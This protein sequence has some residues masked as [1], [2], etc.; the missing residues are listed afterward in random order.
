MADKGFDDIADSTD[1]L[2]TPL[3]GLAAVEAALR[4]QICKD[5]YA[6]PML[7]SCNHTFCS[8]CIRR[9]L[10][11]DGKCPACRS[12][13]E[14]SKLRSNWSMEEAVLAFVRTR[15]DVL[16][17]ARKPPTVLVETVEVPVATTTTTASSAS[18][19]P[20]H[21]LDVDEGKEY[22]AEDQ[23]A[24]RLRSSARRSKTRGAELTAEMAR[25]EASFSMPSSHSVPDQT[26]NDG[27]VACPI[28][29]ERMKEVQVDRH[30][31]SSCPGTPQEQP[32]KQ[33][34]TSSS[35]RNGFQVLSRP[36]APPK[37]ERL[38]TL[39]YSMLKDAQL[40]KKL[41]DLGIPKDGSR[42]ILQKRHQEW[43]TIWNANCDSLH[44]K[45]KSEL[46]QDL[47]VWE[48]T[49]GSR[50]P[51]SS[52]SIHQGA[53]I[54][55]KGF[56][57]AAWSAKHDSSFQ[58]LVASAR[59]SRAQALQKANEGQASTEMSPQQQSA[60]ASTTSMASPSSPSHMH[61]DQNS[62]PLDVSSASE[63]PGPP[64]NREYTPPS[65]PGRS[66]PM[67][68]LPVID[69]AAMYYQLYGTGEPS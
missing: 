42:E 19:P 8:M 39:S 50:A 28:C 16:A 46:L 20:K 12:S 21:A 32:P 47:D 67:A 26:Y 23:P 31:D 11:N 13:Q 52:R 38:P 22:A 49:L 40:R 7:T 30:L 18:P 51:T 60:G 59:K 4:C 10:A 45:R 57:H 2:A 62:L 64:P 36:A 17:L 53:Q 5:F 9:A 68:G 69:T 34:S 54:K 37:P 15:D 25:Q 41:A 65:M 61:V 66:N 43:I 29:L 1:W 3:P 56:D 48:R 6:T 55:D 35:H 14:L 58:D 24:K 63:P 44:P 27:L 33:K